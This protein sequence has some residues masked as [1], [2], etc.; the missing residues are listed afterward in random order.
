[1][2]NAILVDVNRCTGCW[3]C[4]QACRAAYKLDVD[5]YRLFVRTIGGGGIDSS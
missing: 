1:M 2:A 4:S 3:T 5:E